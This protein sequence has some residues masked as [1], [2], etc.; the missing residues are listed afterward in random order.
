MF[1]TNVEAL[2][3]AWISKLLALLFTNPSDRYMLGN[4]LL[5]EIPCDV[6][7]EKNQFKRF[8]TATKAE[9]ISCDVG[10]QWELLWN[11]KNTGFEIWLL[12]PK[13]CAPIFVCICKRHVDKTVN[14]KIDTDNC[15]W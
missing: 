5:D 11:T 3:D 12:V 6:R 7:A 10:R 2:G 4:N 15:T 8:Q 9:Y 14:E 1:F 13:D